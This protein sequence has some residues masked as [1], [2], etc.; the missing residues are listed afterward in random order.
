MCVRGKKKGVSVSVS[1]SGGGGIMIPLSASI[2]RLCPSPL[3]LP[4]L[5]V[6]TEHTEK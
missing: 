6:R 5:L 4:V 3:L 2:A 1:G